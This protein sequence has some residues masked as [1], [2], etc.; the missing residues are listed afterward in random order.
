MSTTEL[1]SLVT[2]S[3]S[4]VSPALPVSSETTAEREETEEADR[5]EEGVDPLMM[6]Y[7]E[8]VR[9]KREE[10]KKTNN[11]QLE[12]DLSGQSQVHEVRSLSQATTD[13]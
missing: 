4:G 7:M 8:L 9:Q 6:K 3:A 13:R 1:S 11:L 10:E 5:G 12:Q 2:T